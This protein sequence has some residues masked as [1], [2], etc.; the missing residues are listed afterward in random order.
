MEVASIDL[1]RLNYLTPIGSLQLD[2]KLKSSLGSIECESGPLIAFEA[3]HDDE[4]S[5]HNNP[6]NNDVRHEE[7]SSSDHI[8]L[9]IFI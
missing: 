8:A 2:C 3:D 9:S 1:V 6:A 5:R 4:H 7:V